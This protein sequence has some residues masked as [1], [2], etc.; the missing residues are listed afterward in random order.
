MLDRLFLEWTLVLLLGLAT[1]SVE[2]V[3]QQISPSSQNKRRVTVA[4]TIQMTRL[5]GRYYFGGGP[6]L[7]KGW[8]RPFLQMADGLPSY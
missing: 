4:D 2:T 7:R 3:A 5:A 6:V 8:L 1:G